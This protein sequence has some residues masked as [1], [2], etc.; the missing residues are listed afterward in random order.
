M[1]GRWL[2]D[3][4]LKARSKMLLQELNW[5][6]Q[7]SDEI[8]RARILILASL[9]RAEIID[10]DPLMK[11]IVDNPFNQARNDL[12]EFYEAI[13]V[14]RNQTKSKHR[15]QHRMVKAV[16]RPPELAFFDKEQ[17]TAGERSLE[18]WMA[19]AG[20]ALVKNGFD[21]GRR[22][23]DMLSVSDASI[24]TAEGKIRELERLS[25]ESI[26]GASSSEQIIALCRYVPTAF[27]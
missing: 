20:A 9:L 26:L 22:I 14:S 25:G 4:G 13:E 7:G 18:V 10:P 15:Q 24:T 17:T 3:A 23:W 5:E 16:G 27:R 8:R 12:A 1:L 21:Y 11:A 6:L 19:T 2:R